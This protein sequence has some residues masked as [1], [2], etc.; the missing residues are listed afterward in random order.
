MPSNLAYV[1]LNEIRILPRNGEFYAE[2]VYKIAVV[3]V[4][5]DANSVLGIDPG[6]NNWLTCV[7]NVGTSFIVDEFHLKSLNQWYNKRVSVLNPHFSQTEF[8]T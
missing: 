3:P 4:D 2:F 5:V 7:S 1:D 6:L 8:K